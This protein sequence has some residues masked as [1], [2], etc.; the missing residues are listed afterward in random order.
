MTKA[1]MFQNLQIE[2]VVLVHS[3]SEFLL[4]KLGVQTMIGIGLS[5]SIRQK[6]S[7]ILITWGP[8]IYYV[9]ACMREWGL[10][11]DIFAYFQS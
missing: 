10:E 7:I 1:E 9:S 3:L 8:F 6:F 2:R 5:V 4:R 11:I